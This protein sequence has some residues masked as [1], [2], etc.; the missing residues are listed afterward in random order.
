MGAKIKYLKCKKILRDLF[1]IFMTCRS[2]SGKTIPEI[3]K[4]PSKHQIL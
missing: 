3:S 2:K 1:Y 4:D